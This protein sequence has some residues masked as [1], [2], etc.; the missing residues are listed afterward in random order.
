MI[1]ELCTVNVVRG[2]VW[3]TPAVKSG[4]ASFQ[5]GFVLCGGCQRAVSYARPEPVD[6]TQLPQSEGGK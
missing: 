4:G 6:D 5:A 3:R 2:T 1:C